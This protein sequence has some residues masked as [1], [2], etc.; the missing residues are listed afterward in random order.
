MSLIDLIKNLI[1]FLVLI[2]LVH[3]QLSLAKNVQVELYEPEANEEPSVMSELD[4]N[5]RAHQSGA[6]EAKLMSRLVD[7]NENP[8]IIFEPNTQE[9]KSVI[10]EAP[11]IKSDYRLVDLMKPKRELSEENTLKE[12]LFKLKLKSLFGVKKRGIHIKTYYDPLIQKDGSI[13]LIPKDLN[14]NHYFIG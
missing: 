9:E 1:A 13:L 14:Q 11:M 12:E 6:K 4:L 2:A 8:S 5:D 3:C 7:F 10:N